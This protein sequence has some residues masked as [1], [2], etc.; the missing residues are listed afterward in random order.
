MKTK[1]RE[2]KRTT[3]AP[4]R[5]KNDKIEG[6]IDNSDGSLLSIVA[7]DGRIVGLITDRDICATA[8]KR[9]PDSHAGTKGAAKRV[10]PCRSDEEVRAALQTNLNWSRVEVEVVGGILRHHHAW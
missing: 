8:A 3:V 1:K 4:R 6:L 10:F 9:R 7:A 2:S 5:R